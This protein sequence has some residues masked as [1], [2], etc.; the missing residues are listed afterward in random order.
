[1]STNTRRLE[2]KAVVIAGTA[3]GLGVGLA[4]RLVSI[5]GGQWMQ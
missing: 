3:R 2:G 4:K 5:N 1:M